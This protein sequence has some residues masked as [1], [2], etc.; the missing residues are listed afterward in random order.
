[1]SVRI[2]ELSREFDMPNKEV[3]E[4]CREAG[5]DV[6]SHS[7]TVDED[8]A[9][10]VRRRLAAVLGD[11][12]DEPESEPGP[13]AVAEPPKPPVPAVPELSPEEQLIQARQRVISLPSRGRAKPKAEGVKLPGRQKPPA[14]GPGAEAA[15]ETLLEQAQRA[16][17]IQEFPIQEWLL[18][19]E[20]WGTRR[21]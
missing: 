15:V 8:E 7:S 12:T 2:H 10:M 6:S 20:R 13:A 18:L 1:M 17:R 16:A 3:I 4:I 19:G 9:V 11:D 14:R 21:A 5:L